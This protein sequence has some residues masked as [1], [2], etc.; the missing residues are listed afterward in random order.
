MEKNMGN[1]D[2]FI[3]IATALLIAFF[4]LT[5]PV[6]GVAAVVSAIIA[7]V[8]FATGLVGF[9]PVYALFGIFAGSKNGT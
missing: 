7:I 8:F 3:R 1:I 5:G 9:C 6:Y 4:Y 2:R